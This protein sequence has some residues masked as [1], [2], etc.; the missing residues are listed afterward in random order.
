MKKMLGYLLIVVLGVA[1]IIAL[2][3]RSESLDNNVAKGSNTI[4]LC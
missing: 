4:V 3:D 2:I 1:S